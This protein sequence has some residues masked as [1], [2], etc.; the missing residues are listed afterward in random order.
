MGTAVGRARQRRHRG[1]A[2]AVI[3]GRC[4]AASPE[5]ILPS[6]GYGFRAPSLALGPRND[7][8][9][10]R[11]I[12]RDAVGQ[13]PGAIGRHERA[14]RDPDHVVDALG[15]GWGAEIEQDR[16]EHH[17][18]ARVEE[19]SSRHLA[20]VDRQDAGCHLRLEIRSEMR[21]AARWT[22][23]IELPSELRHAVGDRDHG[24][25]RR[26]LA[27]AD[28]KL[29][30]AGAQPHQDGLDVAVGRIEIEDA[31]GLIAALLVHDRREQLLLVLEVDVEGPLRHAG[32]ARN[33]AHAGGI[34]AL[35]QEDLARAF[36]DL[37]ALR[38]IFLGR[39]RHSARELGLRG[40]SALPR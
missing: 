32:H 39:R 16:H 9:S 37:A 28:Q 30:E 24:A 6:R 4:E 25:Y 38:I 26:E 3:P 20:V 1:L 34:E 12:V 23:L 14:H 13:S 19:L 2:L 5:S 18:L 11:S 8:P 27:R 40:H 15:G 35:G 10:G 36:D 29:H 33:L 21:D 31:F 7:S 22:G 17:R